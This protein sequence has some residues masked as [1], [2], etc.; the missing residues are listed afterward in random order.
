ML[1]ASTAGPEKVAT[2]RPLSVGAEPSTMAETLELPTGETVS[3]EQAFLFEG[4]PFRF[5]PVDD[6]EGFELSPLY[7][8]GGQMDQRFE[9]RTE[10]VERWAEDPDSR[11]LLTDDEW[12]A[13]IDDARDDDRFVA[14]ELDAIERELGLARGPLARLRGL[15]GL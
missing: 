4:Y 13:W 7:W 11:G 6:G 9:S 12:R 15:L 5:R 3:P 8:G 10:L 1:G 14:E 2:A